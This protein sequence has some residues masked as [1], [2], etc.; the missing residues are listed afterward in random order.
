MTMTFPRRASLVL[1]LGVAVVGATT[2]PAAA[3]PSSAAQARSGVIEGFVF[4]DRDAD[5]LLDPDETGIR[6][7]PVQL[8]GPVNRT[9]LSSMNGAYRF[10]DIPSGTYDVGIAAGEGWQL[11]GQSVYAG[12]AVD[13]D[14]LSDVN[15]GLRSAERLP[16]AAADDGGDSDIAGDAGDSSGADVEDGADVS[17]DATAAT[18]GAFSADEAE[19]LAAAAAL[20]GLT[21]AEEVDPEA[22]QQAIQAAQAG[23][24]DQPMAD[25]LAQALAA[26]STT[27]AA[28]GSD[29]GEA[30]AASDES[31][32][33]S[34]E[35]APVG[36]A[37]GAGATGPA[38]V[39]GDGAY[40]AGAS[41]AGGTIAGM[42]AMGGSNDSAG[43]TA[44]PNW[45]S[46]SKGGAAAPE[47]EMP[48]MPHT[49]AV[50]GGASAL[51]TALMLGLLGV[52]G[53]FVERSGRR[54]V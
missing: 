44:R 3:R 1:A 7:V 12:L 27:D 39:V 6:I 42:A 20:L 33:T 37:T 36:A 26:I 29:D 48:G 32:T 30:A 53:M 34:D 24:I 28:A 43:S 51:A 11:Q 47:R 23:A 50:P 52:V 46:L 5:G 35:A 19:A 45:P 4:L 17:G 31:A 21:T 54:A 25:V 38:G 40:G 10:E 16:V 41:V 22:L 14:S 18:D 2:A 15:F 13:G 8:K 49:G 9:V